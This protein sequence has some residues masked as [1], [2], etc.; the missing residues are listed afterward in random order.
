MPVYFSGWVR[1]DA[2]IR[3]GTGFSVIR[4]TPTGNYRITIPATPS[5]RFL[6]TV[7]T[8]SATNAIARVVAFSRSALDGSSTIDV[9]IHDSV[10]GAFLDSDFN[11]VSIDRS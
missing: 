2:S 4:L 5:G 8:P 9:E 7:V 10:T 6:S 3:F 11:F 1:A